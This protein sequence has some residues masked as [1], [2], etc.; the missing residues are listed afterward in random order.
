MVS[1]T[2]APIDARG[3]NKSVGRCQGAE[4]TSSIQTAKN[5]IFISTTILNLQPS[6]K[7]KDE[8]LNAAN[9]AV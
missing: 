4:I 8:P 2:V 3:I 9:V 5:G 1:G 6:S 7:R